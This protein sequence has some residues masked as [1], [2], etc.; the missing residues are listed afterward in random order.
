MRL[1]AHLLG[2]IICALCMP[3]CT[4]A[5]VE[6]A[7]KEEVRD[8]RVVEITRAWR[9][10]ETGMVICVRGWP[11]E[12]ARTAPAVEYHM[13]VPLAL[14]ED[15]EQPSPLLVQEEG[16]R[17]RTIVVP[18]DRAGAGC[19]ERPE[20]A[21]D[22]RTVTVETDYFASVSPREASDDQIERFADPT[23][24]DI[25]LF[26]FEAPS[27]PPAVALLYRH[28]MPVFDGY[29]LVWIDPGNKPVKPNEAAYLALP[30]AFA[31]D[32]A[33][34]VGTIIVFAVALAA[35]A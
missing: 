24:A 15:P 17:I 28:D 23:A 13:T 21:S 4:G 16:R 10:G 27:E 22:I 18:A 1:R 12:R 9:A 35:G 20:S 14:F 26:G 34:V 11:A 3:G 32:V 29:R 33:I 25:V 31:I 6:Y 30:V 8:N 7:G 19:P 5:V 2:A